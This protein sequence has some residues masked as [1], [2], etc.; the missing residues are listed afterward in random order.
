[1]V[2]CLVVVGA[3]VLMSTGCGQGDPDLYKVSGTLTHNGQPIPS[4]EV[5]FLPEDT[6]T[7]RESFG[8]TDSEGHFVMKMSSREG[9]APGKHTIYVRD[10]AA[11]H[12]ATTSDDSAYQAV[13]EK[14][15]DPETSPK[16]LTVDSDLENYELKLD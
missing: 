13:L 9:V 14:Y 2:G 5:A 16:T 8:V 10:P 1:M 12:G 15:G 11:I 3:L 7:K 6:S 4:M